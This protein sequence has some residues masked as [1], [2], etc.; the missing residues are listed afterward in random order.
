MIEVKGYDDER[1]KPLSVKALGLD[2][3]L[4]SMSLVEWK[5]DRGRPKKHVAE[6]EARME[7]GQKLPA[8][9]LEDSM[10]IGIPNL[11]HSISDFEAIIEEI[12][13]AI[14]EEHPIP[15]STGEKEEAREA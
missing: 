7:D 6:V 1:I 5:M 10:I 11:A 8:T 13:N 3:G 2:R 15:N 14:Y 4:S 12:D 9:N